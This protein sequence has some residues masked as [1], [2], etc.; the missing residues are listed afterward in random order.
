MTGTKAT[1]GAVAALT[2][3]AMALLLGP[4]LPVLAATAS[5]APAAAEVA[6]VDQ[7]FTSGNL[8][9]LINECC[10]LVAQTF[11]AGLSGVLA[12]VNVDVFDCCSST[13][14]LRVAITTVDPDHR[15][16]DV[17]LGQTTVGT[18][19][20]GLAQLITFPQ[21]IPVEAG[22]EYAIVLSYP[23]GPPPGAG[24]AQGAWLGFVGDGYPR[25]RALAYV[26]GDGWVESR[27]GLDDLP[28]DL[29][30]RTYVARLSTPAD[31]EECKAGGWRELANEQGQ[32]FDSQGACVRFV[33]SRSK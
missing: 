1:L 20:P 7:S 31:R 29:H 12:G 23:E 9:S 24:G 19:C 17:V 10:A 21:T 11:T 2:A 22:V 15:P 16:T 28:T 6:V 8:N 27:F 3:A 30:F 33:V 26:P 14:S 4:V 13:A 5:G 25:G 32:P 18:C